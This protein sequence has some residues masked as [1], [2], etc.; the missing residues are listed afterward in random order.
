[1][2]IGHCVFVKIYILD[3]NSAGGRFLRFVASYFI[4]YFKVYICKDNCM[5]YLLKKFEHFITSSLSVALISMFLQRS[6]S[7]A[8]GRQ[9]FSYVQFNGG[10]QMNVLIMSTADKLM[11]I[12]CSNFL[13]R[14]SLGLSSHLYT[15]TKRKKNLL[16]KILKSALA[17]N[18]D[19]K[20]PILRK[21]NFQFS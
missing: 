9:N 16:R 18:F 13:R 21:R 19:P 15:L 1:M 5:C 7:N 10:I 20:C 12:K 4:G 17:L 8:W 2:K 11:M 3:Q 6:Y 14:S